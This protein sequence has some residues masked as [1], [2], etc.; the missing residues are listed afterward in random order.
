MKLEKSKLTMTTYFIM[1]S[2]AMT[3]LTLFC[4]PFEGVYEYRYY[5]LG[6]FIVT[7]IY[8]IWSSLRDP[9]YIKKSDK[10]SFLKLN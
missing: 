9:G 3:L 10:I 2:L 1:L 7:N 5:V 8:F 4:M 6:S